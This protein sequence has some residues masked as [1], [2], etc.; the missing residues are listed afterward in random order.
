MALPAGWPPRTASGQKSLRVYLAGTCTADFDA[1]AYLFS[2]TDIPVADMVFANASQAIGNPATFTFTTGAPA[3]TVTRSAGSFVTDGFK[4]GGSMTVESATTPANDGSYVIVGVAALT[5]T[6]ADATFDTYEADPLA[7]ISVD[8]GLTVDITSAGSNLPLLGVGAQFEV[9]DHATNNGT[10]QVTAVTTPT[11]DITVLA[12]DVTPVNATTEPVTIRDTSGNP[13]I[14]LPV[15]N[16]GASTPVT[17]DS[18]P[19]GGGQNDLGAEAP[20]I[21]SETILVTA[22]AAVVEISFDGINVHGS[23]PSGQTRQYSG[24]KEAG[25]AVR[26][27]GATFAIEAW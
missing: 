14:P 12:L 6:F 11:D 10:Y 20:M 19:M 24:R 3:D 13:Y 15:V 1:N 16:P 21:F 25:I 5:L 27:T 23:V 9:R 17:L 2:R 22:T 8:N 18:N 4:I 26:G 7:Q